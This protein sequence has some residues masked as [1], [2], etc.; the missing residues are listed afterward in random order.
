MFVYRILV[1]VAMDAH[2][3]GLS[4]QCVYVCVC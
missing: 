3:E 1:E 2:T 4:N